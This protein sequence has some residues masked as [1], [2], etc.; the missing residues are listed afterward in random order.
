MYWCYSY[1]LDG[2]L[3]SFVFSN[4]NSSSSYPKHRATELTTS[5]V[6]WTNLTLSCLT[7]CALTLTRVPE[8]SPSAPPLIPASPV[9][10]L[11]R[12]AL[13]SAPAT[14]PRAWIRVWKG[15][16]AGEP[17]CHSIGT[18]LRVNR[19]RL[20]SH[21]SHIVMV[22]GSERAGP[23]HWR[24]RSMVRTWRW[25]VK[26]I[27]P[28]LTACSSLHPLCPF[29]A[30]QIGPASSE[31]TLTRTAGHSQVPLLCDLCFPSCALLSCSSWRPACVFYW[32]L[33][34]CWCSFLY[35]TLSKP[36]LSLVYTSTSKST[37]LNYWKRDIE[38]YTSAN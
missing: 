3:N 18:P 34:T 29:L 11:K 36:Q 32:V 38:I 10:A 26:V 9:H 13:H 27:S 15:Q 4:Q 30:P 5:G 37:L 21:P 14:R 22:N 16:V 7:S 17:S 19:R 23:R 33:W 28:S 31:R 8:T 20:A 12:T 1:F 6:C 35:Q 24:R 25:W 2:G